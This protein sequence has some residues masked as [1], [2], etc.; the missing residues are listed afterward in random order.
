MKNNYLLALLICF[1]AASISAQQVWDNFQN[2][3]KGNYGFINGSFIPYFENPDKSGVNTSN[4]VASYA[5]N[6]T[7]LFDVLILEAPMAD[8]SDY[9]SGTK[10]MSVDVWSPNVGTVVQITLESSIL[11]L[12]VNYPVGRHSVFLGTTTVANAWETITFSFSERPDLTVSNTGVDRIVLLFAPNTNTST[13]F[14]FDN[15]SGPEL[16]NDPCEGVTPNSQILNDFECYQNV[17]YIFS[18]SGINFKRLPNPDQTINIS[19][20]VATYT[21]NGGEEFDVLIGLFDGNLALESNST[22]AFDVWD[23]AAPST[24]RL[25]LQTLNND[26]I[27]AVDATTTTSS[28]WQTLTFDVSSVFESTDIGQFVILLDPQTFTSGQYFFDNFKFGVPVSINDID[29]L[30]SLKLYPNP[31]ANSATLSYEL[32][33]SAKVITTISDAQGR[34][35]NTI[36]GNNTAGFQQTIISTENLASGIYFY[37]LSMGGNKTQGKFIVSH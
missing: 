21:R 2:I 5:R 22:L 19:N 31:S 34:I 6:S 13:T 36:E 11:A 18:S 10:Q 30:T 20:Y 3:R 17:D 28:T 1:C 26:V 27:I 33:S 15:L 14:Y 37:T 25:S 9:V 8:L 7:E 4:V 35:L 29:G 23:P 32:K 24:F 12:P 16:V